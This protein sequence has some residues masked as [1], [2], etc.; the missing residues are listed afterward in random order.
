[1]KI[2]NPT[3]GSDFEMPAVSIETQ[4]PICVI[5]KL[6]GTKISPHPIG[7]D[8]F[9]QVDC[10][11]AEMNIPP[12]TSLEDWNYYIDYCIN[13][14]NDA[15]GLSGL[16]LQIASSMHYSPKELEHPDACRFGCDPSYDAYTGK[17]YETHVRNAG[18]MRSFGFHQHVG[19]YIQDGERFNIKEVRRFIQLCDIYLGLPS[20]VL[21]ED[22]ERRKIYGRGGDYRIKRKGESG[23]LLIIEY[24][25]LGSNMLYHRDF[26][27]NQLNKVVEAY[28]N[29]EQGDPMIKEIINSNEK[30][31]A[32]YFL[33]NKYNYVWHTL[34]SME[35]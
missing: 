10:T 14:T 2:V 28:N 15:L 24:R 25:T 5:G 21:D 6:N 23:K 8:C 18:N 33:N 32:E 29:G 16:K 19:F 35:V 27:F 4:E 13:K 3:F 34:Q 11:A 30:Q 31:A 20:L 1:M 9:Y 22:T 7:E 12:V 17:V 26:V